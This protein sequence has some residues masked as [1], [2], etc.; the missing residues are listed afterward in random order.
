MAFSLESR[1]LAT[2]YNCTAVRWKWKFAGIA[3][4]SGQAIIIHIWRKWP[5]KSISTICH[6]LIFVFPCN[7][8]ICGHNYVYLWKLTDTHDNLPMMMRNVCLFYS[9][10]CACIF[11]SGPPGFFSPVDLGEIEI[12]SRKPSLLVLLLLLCENSD[13]SWP[14]SMHAHICRWQ[15]K[16]NGVAALRFDYS[17]LQRWKGNEVNATLKTMQNY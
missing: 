12:Y 6:Q 2:H 10:S 13:V 1:T 16:L 7:P 8:F 5:K 17:K 11:H 15:N 3:R 9:E 14:Y 4:I